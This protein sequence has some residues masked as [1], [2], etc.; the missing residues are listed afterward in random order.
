MDLPGLPMRRLLLSSCRT[1][2]TA[3]ITLLLGAC[4][5]GPDYQAPAEPAADA[6]RIEN[7]TAGDNEPG[8]KDGSASA[9]DAD[10]AIPSQAFDRAQRVRRDW[11]HLFGSDR[12]DALIQRALDDSPTLA[13][14]QARIRAAREVVKE[15]RGALYPQINVGAGYDRRRVT[16]AQF[17]INDPQF[18]NVFNFYDAQAT[19]S[20]D[21]DLFGKTR[22]RIEASNA[23][24]D[25]QQFQVI[26]TYVTLI[27]NVVATA[28]AEAGLNAAIQTTEQLARSQ[29]KTLGIVGKQIQ[30]GAAIDADATQIRTQLA[31]T[32]A[33]LEPL[34]KQKT[35]AVN[36]LAVL[37]GAPP[38]QFEDPDFSLDGLRLPRQ[39]PVSLPGQLVKQRPDILASAAAVHAA[40]AEIGVATANL[41]PDLTISGSYSRQ[42]LTPGDLGDP[43]NALYTL[44]AQLAAPIFAGGRLRAQRRQ[45]QD[46]YVAALADYRA[47]ALAAFGDVANALRSLEADARALAAQRTALSAA[48]SN[49]DT[50]HTQLTHGAA[51]Y[52]ALYTAQAQYENA[53]LDYTEARVTRYRDTADLFRALGGGWADD[54]GTPLPA[55]TGIR[56]AGT[57]TD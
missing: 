21:L 18:T 52:V 38:G 54:D 43:V 47:T 41:L 9:S 23:R 3:A 44:G 31:R 16:G 7:A 19:A 56:A 24:L 36:R 39:L 32:R 4:A 22:R 40:S 10:R 17:G 30:Y 50:V 48:Q 33:S 14:G 8:R 57:Q 28:I 53:E 1:F 51:D 45:A 5:V 6:Y 13:A 35:L 26:D 15:N 34:R 29:K 49:L 2:P 27:N 55:A 11:Y 42:A 46:L 25:E 20:Y 37:V 12:L